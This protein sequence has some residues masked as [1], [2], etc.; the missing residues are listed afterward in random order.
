MP[1]SDEEG[2][3][4]GMTNKAV[5]GGSI[6]LID[7]Q[8]GV[9]VTE[10]P[11]DVCVFLLDGG[12]QETDGFCF[13]P[14]DAPRVASLLLPEGTVAVERGRLERVLAAAIEMKRSAEWYGFIRTQV[15]AL[16]P[17]DLDPLPEPADKEGGEKVSEP[18]SNRRMH[19][20]CPH[21]GGEAAVL[22][23]P[24]AT[25]EAMNDAADAPESATA[26]RIVEAAREYAASR[27][28]WE[29]ALDSASEVRIDADV[30]GQICRRLDAA[31]AN[32]LALFAEPEA[33][34]AC[35]HDGR[36]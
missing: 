23:V 34:A 21:C 31:R 17:G 36:E 32:L 29:D 33:R 28:A 14:D 16:Q 2:E 9:E 18:E 8:C 13:H 20:I 35:A 26:A 11:D 24:I 15:S 7:C 3:R 6:R 5:R 22:S 27:R 4:V 30:W 1:V 19:L 12:G 25:L 10:G